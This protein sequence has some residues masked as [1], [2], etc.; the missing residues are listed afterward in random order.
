MR[1]RNKILLGCFGLPVLFFTGLVLVAIISI[2][3]RGD[4]EPQDVQ[5]AHRISD[6]ASSDGDESGAVAIDG[7]TPTP[8]EL[9]SGQELE[10][11]VAEAKLEILPG[12]PDGVIEIEGRFDPDHYE[13]TQETSGNSTHIYFDQ[14]SRIRFAWFK[15]DPDNELTIRVPTNTPVDL[16]IEMA[17]GKLDAD[18]TGVPIQHMVVNLATGQA[19]VEFD[20][21]NPVAMSSFYTDIA[22]GELSIE[23]LG[24]AGPE[25][26]SIN[27]VMGSSR[28]DFNGDWDHH[29][30][31]D[32][33]VVMGEARIRFPSEAVIESKG[34]SAVMGSSDWLRPKDK[35]EEIDVE[36]PQSIASGEVSGAVVMGSIRIR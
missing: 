21:A 14:R 36:N 8:I 3:L 27:T 15:D 31:T 28:I 10:I 26:V 32:I 12:A 4:P 19:R 25:L 35:L 5:V 33:N 13:L 7:A 1:L 23:G 9:T 29:I 34:I 17:M 16:K 30:E 22:M 2:A 24:F 20:E 6:A 18:L 11:H